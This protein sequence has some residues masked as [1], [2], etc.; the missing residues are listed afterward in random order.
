MQLQVL[1]L[2]KDNFGRWCTQFKAL[3]GSQD[4]WDIVNLGFTDPTPEE[5]RN[6]L[7]DQRKKDKKAL[8]L[9][10]QGLDDDTFEKISEATSSKEVWDK[11]AIIYKGVERVKKQRLQ[12]LRGEFETA[13]MKEREVVSDY[14]SRLISIVNQMKRNGEKLEDVRFEHVVVAIEESKDLEIMTTEELLGSLRVHELRIR[15]HDEVMGCEQALE[16]KMSFD[17]GG[18]GRGRDSLT[19]RG[20]GRGRGSPS[21]P[22]NLQ[23]GE[24][25]SGVQCWNCKHYGHYA[26]E[27]P[28]KEDKTANFAEGSNNVEDESSLLFVHDEPL[29]GGDLWYLD[30]GASNHM[31]GR[32]EVFVE[33]HDHI[34]GPVTLGDTS[35]LAIAGK[36]KIAIYQKNG[37][38][39][40]IS[41][42]YYIPNMKSNILSLGQL[43]QKGHI[44]HMENNLLELRNAE[45]YLIARVR[46]TKNRM[47]P[48]Y[49][50]T[51]LERCL[52]SIIESEAGRWHLRFG[53]LHFHGLK[54]L[55]TRSMVRGLPSL[56]VPNHIC[57]TCVI[58][59]QAR[60]PF[61]TGGTWRAQETLQLVHTDICGPLEPKSF[62]GN[63]YFITFIDDF[64]RKVWVYFLKEKSAT[65][66][67]FK[68][69]KAYS[70]TESGNKLVTILVDSWE[71]TPLLFFRISAKNMAFNINSQLH[72][73][74]SK[75]G[76][77]NERTVRSWT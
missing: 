30:S 16:S 18:R 43:L 42:V 31:C 44:I 7:K 71:S 22:R 64:S 8:F 57:A 6:A 68:T 61:P 32:K 48:L 23:F 35:K 40:F 59:K 74:L 5:Q 26:S 19:S 25:R 63:R 76:L 4:L 2:K 13:H 20:R 24:G 67:V 45:R 14:H 51:K 34:C 69:F 53:H 12:T 72:I 15:R 27:C 73:H 39:T 49:L 1:L 21:K 70:E 56:E 9:L 33:L 60:S 75:M 41:G 37:A 66:D 36:G 65:F 47:F 55:S 62:G 77:L 3:F 29:E 50:N 11:L 17:G 54:L 10:Y 52:A 46:M 58:G 38:K 28:S